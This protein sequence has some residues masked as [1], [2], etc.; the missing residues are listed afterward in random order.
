MRKFSHWR[1][2]LNAFPTR[3]SG[4]LVGIALFGASEKKGEKPNKS[5]FAFPTSP[6]KK[7]SIRQ[8]TNGRSNVGISGTGSFI[9]VLLDYGVHTSFTQ[10]PSYHLLYE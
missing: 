8:I 6:N 4:L 7:I 10:S 2:Y 1:T 5:P 9:P 3:V